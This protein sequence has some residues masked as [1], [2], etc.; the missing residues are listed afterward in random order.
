MNE[1]MNL[2]GRG[3]SWTAYPYRSSSH[4]SA[5]GKKCGNQT[6]MDKVTISYTDTSVDSVLS[7]VTDL[8]FQ[9]DISPFSII[10]LH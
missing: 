7:W 6:D 2:G 8:P 10:P 3:S 4:R 5:K 1:G 9:T